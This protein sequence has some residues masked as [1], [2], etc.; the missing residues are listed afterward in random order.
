MQVLKQLENAGLDLV[1]VGIGLSTPSPVPW[2]A[3]ALVNTAGEVRE[4]AGLPVTTSW[5]ITS[6]KEADAAIRS[7]KLAFVM[8]ARRLL[9]NPH[10]PHKPAREFL[11]ASKLVASVSRSHLHLLPGVLR[12]TLPTR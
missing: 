6:A 10:W 12:A 9:D 2:A 1:D 5:L 3:N 11:L 8:L 4:Q 7:G